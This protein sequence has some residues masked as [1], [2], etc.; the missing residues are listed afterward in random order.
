MNDFIP[1]QFSSVQY[2]SIGDVIALIKSLGRACYMAKID[3][4]AFRIIHPDDYHL[5]GMTWINS[6]LGWQG[7]PGGE[8]TCLP[9]MWP[10]F[11]FR[12]R[13][14]MC[15]E[16]NRMDDSFPDISSDPLETLD[17]VEFDCST[18]IKEI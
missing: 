7:W 16:P 13:C 10:G 14:H 17:E 8:S 3:I 4:T 5:L 15:F 2:A 11:D 1:D 12:T 18:G 6:Y 9:P